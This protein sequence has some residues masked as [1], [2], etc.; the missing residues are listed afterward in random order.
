VAAN[1][2]IEESH[3]GHQTGLERLFRDN[4]VGCYCRFW[5]F[6]GWE[7]E[8]MERCTEPERNRK[9]LEHGLGC[10]SVDARGLVATVDARVVGWLKLAPASTLDKLYGRRPYGKMPCFAGDRSGVFTIGCV[11]VDAAW[12]RQGIARS[13]IHEGVRAAARWGATSVE[14]LPRDG[15]TDPCLLQMGPASV[16]LE[17]GFEIV[18]ASVTA[19]PVMRKAL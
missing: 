5:H 6:D 12:R 17:A 3:Q 11:L 13:L 9:E 16:F 14:A 7:I 4:T 1:V 8:W 18:D 15:A 2:V 19:H 10:N